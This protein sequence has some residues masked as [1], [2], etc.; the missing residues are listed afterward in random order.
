MFRMHL[1]LSEKAC[2]E[3]QEIE[4]LLLSKTIKGMS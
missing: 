1:F 2:G 4:I 3:S